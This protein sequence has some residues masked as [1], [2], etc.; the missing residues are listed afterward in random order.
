MTSTSEADFGRSWQ[1]RASIAGDQATEARHGSD[2][3]ARAW[4]VGVVLPVM[5]KS[6]GEEQLTL[7]RQEQSGEWQFVASFSRMHQA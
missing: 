5:S 7:E 4:A 3:D 6:L 2:K 1:Y